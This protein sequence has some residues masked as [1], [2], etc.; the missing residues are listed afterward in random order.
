[1]WIRLLE[2]RAGPGC[3]GGALKKGT[4]LFWDDKSDARRFIA[5]GQAEE[6]KA[7]TKGDPT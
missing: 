6:A 5:A 2:D 4:V 7:P 1:M 3:K